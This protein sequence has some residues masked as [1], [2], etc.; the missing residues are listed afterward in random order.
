M[1][2]RPYQEKGI[3]DIRA[4]FIQGKRRVCYAAP[5][6]SGKT[7]LF[8]HAAK[9][10]VENGQR[11][12]INVHRQELIDQT[13]AALTTEGVSYGIIAA[14]Y[15]ENPD[16]PLQIAMV[17]TLVR[18]LDRLRNVSLSIVDEAHHIMA[19]TW[20][21]ITNA[22][23]NARILGVTA[24]PERLDGRGLGAVFDGLVLGP[25]VNELIASGW[26]VPFVVY[27]PERMV[28]LKGTRTVAGDYALGDLARRMSADVVLGDA[29]VE[30]RKH[31]DGNTAI[32]F[33][34]TI[35]HSL[36]VARFFRQHGIEA[37]H[38][39][40]DTPTAER[41]GLLAALA[42]GEI[43]ILTNCALIAEGLDIPSVGGVILLRP[44][45]SLALH[46][47]Q[48]GRA[49]R[50]AP[51][52]QRA[53][54]LD[55]AGNVFRHGMPDMEHKWSLDGRPKKKGKALAR[56]C[57]ACGTLIAIS[58][59]T[60][61]E[62]GVDLRPPRIAPAMTTEPLIELDGAAAFEQWLAHG[63]FKA[64]IGCAGNDEARLSQ[65]AKARGYK[66]GWVWWRLQAEREAEDAALLNAAFGK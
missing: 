39:D 10:V 36:N 11:A 56:R 63:S 58:A 24:T 19:S 50:P 21:K 22:T 49:L 13:C 18:R 8:T 44:T 62:C 65:V 1:K 28:N 9:K 35:D 12:V 25:T 2:L 57:L 30:Y 16:A 31:L 4:L 53:V 32:A 14:G 20:L 27:A 59:Q 46:L 38:L 40:G 3:A 33:C 54:I 41:R 6:A 64:V 66:P 34:T 42:A 47:Q 37:R 51:G 5:T 26:L 43:K 7:I 60:C 55:H 23:P 45:K 17:Q 52:K 15:P 29:V 48:I 61:P